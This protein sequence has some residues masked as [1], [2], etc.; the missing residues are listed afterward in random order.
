MHQHLVNFNRDRAACD[1]EQFFGQRSFAGADF[2]DRVRAR[3]RAGRFSDLSQNG[4]AGEKM[5]PEAAAQVSLARR[6]GWS[7]SAGAPW[8][9]WAVRIRLPA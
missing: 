4:F 7:P 1:G 6:C 2:N 8:K 5:L 9:P 3:V